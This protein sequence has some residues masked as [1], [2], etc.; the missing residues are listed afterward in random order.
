MEAVIARLLMGA[1][2]VRFG[3]D[4][5]HP[6]SDVASYYPDLGFA[7]SQQSSARRPFQRVL[8]FLVRVAG[9][10]LR[11]APSGSAYRAASVGRGSTAIQTSVDPGTRLWTNFRSFR[12]NP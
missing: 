3:A 1:P 4:H 8:D 7:D 6:H 10:D 9:S 5:L 2:W 12:S 11:F